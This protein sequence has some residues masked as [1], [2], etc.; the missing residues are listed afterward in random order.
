M[1]NVCLSVG[2]LLSLL[3]VNIIFSDEAMFHLQD[4]EPAHFTKPF[5][6]RLDEHGLRIG[7]ESL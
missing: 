6:L 3:C 7:T 4:G 1:E 2:D 5:R